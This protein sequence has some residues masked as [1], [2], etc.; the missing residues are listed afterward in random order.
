MSEPIPPHK[1]KVSE[2]LAINEDDIA[3]E[4]FEQAGHV[5]RFGEAKADA[6]HELALAKIRLDFLEA[7]LTLAIRRDPAA[8]DLP[9]KPT[10]KAISASVTVHP[11]YQAALREVNDLQQEVAYRAVH[12]DAII[13]KRRSMEGIV[14]VREME[15]YDGA[16]RSREARAAA[17]EGGKAAARRPVKKREE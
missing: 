2:V 17:A 6:Q 12:C 13:E 4:F 9:D 16:P 7:E 5:R 1:K 15:Y 8:H 14:D 10:E 11:Q 3:G